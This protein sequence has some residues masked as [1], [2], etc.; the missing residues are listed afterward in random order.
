MMCI[1]LIVVAM[2]NFRL[3]CEFVMGDMQTH[4]FKFLDVEKFEIEDKKRN[5]QTYTQKTYDE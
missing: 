5:P 2:N 3:K 1:K 4:D